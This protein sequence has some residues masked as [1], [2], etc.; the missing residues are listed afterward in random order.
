[1]KNCAGFVFNVF[2]QRAVDKQSKNSTYSLNEW[3]HS[4]EF[5]AGKDWRGHTP[6]GFPSITTQYN[7]HVIDVFV[8]SHIHVSLHWK[9][10]KVL[11]VSIVMNLRLLSYEYLVLP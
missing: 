5:P 7:Q 11:K 2:V 1:M 4:F 3:K 9:V 10:V 8:T 6:H